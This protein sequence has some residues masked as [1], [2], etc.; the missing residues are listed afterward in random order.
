LESVR[1]HGHYAILIVVVF[2]ILVILR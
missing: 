2:F 1:Q